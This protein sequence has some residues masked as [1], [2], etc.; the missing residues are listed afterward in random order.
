MAS[1]L[2]SAWFGYVP[3]Q[4]DPGYVRVMSAFGLRQWRGSAPFPVIVEHL[5][6]PHIEATPSPRSAP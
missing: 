5:A 1:W 6:Q 3:V 2:L 4:T